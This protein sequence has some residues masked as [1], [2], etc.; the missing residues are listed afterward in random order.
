M[1]LVA[2][3]LS[4]HFIHLFGNLKGISENVKKKYFIYKFFE[5]QC[6]MKRAALLAKVYGPLILTWFLY[7]YQLRN[8]Y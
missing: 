6:N 4:R 8:R 1:I 7:M 3:L 2:C 5:V